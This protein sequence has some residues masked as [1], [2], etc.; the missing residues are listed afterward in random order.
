M[1][2]FVI[3]YRIR[4]DNQQMDGYQT[5]KVKDGSMREAIVDRKFHFGIFP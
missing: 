1:D 4:L 5:R 3:N 2:E